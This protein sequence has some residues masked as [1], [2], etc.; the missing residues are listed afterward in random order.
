MKAEVTEWFDCHLLY[1]SLGP[2]VITKGICNVSGK[3]HLH[4]DLMRLII[5]CFP[6]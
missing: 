1:D 5:R 3:L 4:R 2:F 6:V